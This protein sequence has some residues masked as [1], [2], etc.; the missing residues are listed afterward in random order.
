MSAA[1]ATVV[2]A[3]TNDESRSTTHAERPWRA[4]SSVVARP[5][6]PLRL[7]VGQRVALHVGSP[8]WIVIR[9]PDGV[10]LAELPLVVPPETWF[11]PSTVEGEL[12]Y[13]SRT[14]AAADLSE[15]PVRPNR[16]VTRVTLI[17]RGKT[18]VDVERL[19]L[20]VP[21]LRLGLDE[22]S[23]RLVTE[24]LE[25]ERGEDEEATVRVREL[26][27]GAEVL[28]APREVAR[29]S[30]RHKLGALWA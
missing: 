15:M 10:E 7:P 1:K 19:R 20:P 22:A 27:A 8:L 2:I 3:S 6:T 25:M 5:V 4:S 30:W 11:G 13:A 18:A 26:P 14:H 17:N 12:C 24:A 23:G 21:R 28:A 16:A 9:L 29:D